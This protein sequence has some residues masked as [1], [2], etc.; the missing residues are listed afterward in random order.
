[1]IALFSVENNYDQP[2]NNLVALFKEKPSL[3]AIATAIGLDFPST[4][5]KISLAIVNVWNSID[6]TSGIR[7]MDTDYRLESID[8]TS[9]I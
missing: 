5:D 2:E 7:I 6:S 4:N 8:F 1:M 9:H 3:T